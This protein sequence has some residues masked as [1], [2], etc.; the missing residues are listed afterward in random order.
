M[1]G[2]KWVFGKISKNNKK[3][4]STSF[5]LKKKYLSSR[6]KCGPERVKVKRRRFNTEKKLHWR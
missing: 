1:N 6:N 5:E 4:V 3:I 2:K